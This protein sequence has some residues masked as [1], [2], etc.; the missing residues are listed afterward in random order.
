MCIVDALLAVLFV[1]V[2]A[3]LT[4]TILFAQFALVDFMAPYLALCFVLVI[5][6]VATIHTSRCKYLLLDDPNYYFHRAGGYTVAR[7]DEH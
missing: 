3:A 2:F 1:A 7:T 4:P 5:V 6:L